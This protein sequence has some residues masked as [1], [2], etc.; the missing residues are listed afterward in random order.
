MTDIATFVDGFD[1]LPA[2]W[3]GAKYTVVGGDPGFHER[4]AGPYHGEAARFAG[5]DRWLGPALRSASGP[6]AN[7]DNPWWDAGSW[8]A[9]V[10]LSTAGWSGEVA[11]LAPCYYDVVTEAVIDWPH[12]WL[13]VDASGTVRVVSWRPQP[14]D[15][16]E[17][18]TLAESAPG[19]WPLGA[20]V[21]VEYRCTIRSDSPPAPVG[22]C[23][24]RLDETLVLAASGLDTTDPQRVA[25]RAR[26]FRFGNIGTLEGY[27]L[28]ANG[29]TV[30]VDD[31][32]ARCDDA[33]GGPLPPWRGTHRVATRLPVG[34]GSRT[35][36]TVV[37][38]PAG[39]NW[40]ACTDLPAADDPV[41]GE[42]DPSYVLKSPD[43]MPV[44]LY[45]LDAFP[46]FAEGAAGAA[47]FHWGVVR[48][49]LP[50]T[51]PPVSLAT[52]TAV[53]SRLPGGSVSASFHTIGGL[54]KCYGGPRPSVD[55]TALLN[56]DL[57][58]L[59]VGFGAGSAPAAAPEQ[60]YRGTQRAVELWYRPD[61][62]PAPAG[63]QHWSVG[64]VP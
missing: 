1:H 41:T 45:A 54:Y 36:L 51:A 40:A 9:N 8:S 18:R 56:T 10:R 62:P 24:L 46:T 28:Y 6:L 5:S 2:V 30:D 14:D 59:E 7:G 34:A 3:C 43:A 63:A 64:W 55:V 4:T 21:G 42:A 17:I 57:A 11:L 25:V 16:P 35:E 33:L 49:A 61:A 47:A 22:V 12:H 29:V 44:D 58:G 52:S 50:G 38:Q 13:T 32:C 27:T 53:A 48:Y 26:Y 31:V 20:W 15:Y 37:G 39:A 60:H 19:V 23:E